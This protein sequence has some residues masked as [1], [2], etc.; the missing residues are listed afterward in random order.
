MSSSKF[1]L[2]G[3]N[4]GSLLSPY[5]AEV[6]LSPCFQF[7]TTPPPPTDPQPSDHASTHLFIRASIFKRGVENKTKVDSK[8]QG[9]NNR[10]G[11]GA[12][13]PEPKLI[14][15]AGTQ[16]QK[17]RL[18]N[19]INGACVRVCVPWKKL[20]GVVERPAFSKIEKNLSLLSNCRY[21]LIDGY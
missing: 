20:Q 17:F 3:R 8:L 2:L 4:R 6:T 21:R 11:H 18:N 9:R 14:W 15:K 5:K 7:I 19:P 10:R 13:S 16:K 12:I 1:I